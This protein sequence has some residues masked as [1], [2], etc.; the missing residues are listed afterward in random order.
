MSSGKLGFLSDQLADPE[1]AWSLG[2]FG[3]IAEF[4]RDADEATTLD[5]ADGMISVV[6]ALGGIR[7]ETHGR[8]RPIASESSTTE[9][10]SHRVAL[11]L[12]QETCAMNRRVVLT[13]VGPDRNALR[14]EDR[15]TVLFDLGLGALQVDA[16]VRSGDPAVIA[17][18]SSVSA[19]PHSK[20]C[21]LTTASRDSSSSRGV[22]SSPSSPATNL[23]EYRWT[24]I[25]SPAP[26][27]VW[28]YAVAGIGPVIRGACRLAFSPR[29]F[30]PGRC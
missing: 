18:P 9:S 10:W 2:A 6:T 1:V 22:L 3:V 16:Y 20:F 8:L 13:E 29:P 4:T 25:G 26:R 11:C 7:I 30:R 21:W 15:K 12:P 14:A 17:D 28:R 23:L 19:T 5:R 24:A 27:C